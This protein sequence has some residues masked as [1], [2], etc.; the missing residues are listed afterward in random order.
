MKNLTVPEAGPS[1]P[2]SVAVSCTVA[3]KSAVEALES[4]TIVGGA[5]V[6]KLPVTKFFSSAVVE[7]DAR[8][9]ARNEVKHGTFAPRKRDCRLT[10]PSKKLATGNVP[11]EPC[12]GVYDHGAVSS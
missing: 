10:P 8:V 11:A 2:L 7:V 3:P 4:V 5:H 12:F 6:L 9:S 1:V